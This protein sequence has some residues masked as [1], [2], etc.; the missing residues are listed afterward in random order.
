MIPARR[1][2]AITVGMPAA[3][4]SFTASSL[5]TMVK[6]DAVAGAE[7]VAFAIID[8]CPIRKDLGYT[9]RAAGPERRLLILW[10]L[11][12]LTEHFAARCLKKAGTQPRFADRFQDPNG[13]D[14]GNI[15]CVFRNVEAH[16]HVALCTEMINFVRLQFVKKLHQID[17][18]TE[19]AVVQKHSNV[20]NVRIGVKMID[21]RSVERAGA[22]DDP[23]DFVA[24]LQQQISQVTSVLPGDTGD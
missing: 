20:V 13:A 14:A 15:R 16:A 6:Q 10:Y 11:L 21:A 17:R 7:T 9:I 1:P 3:T 18:I 5:V 23:V 22:S 2:F 19:V 4:A 24:F 8:G 12:G